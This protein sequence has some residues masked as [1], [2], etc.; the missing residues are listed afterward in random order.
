MMMPPGRWS[1]RLVPGAP[2]RQARHGA[3]SQFA[4]QSAHPVGL[5]LADREIEFGLDQEEPRHVARE[6]FQRFALRGKLGLESLKP[7]PQ[8]GNHLVGRQHPDDRKRSFELGRLALGN[9][10]QLA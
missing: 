10:D 2:L 9:G 8:K 1:S 7:L 4:E 5:G 3:G 6:S